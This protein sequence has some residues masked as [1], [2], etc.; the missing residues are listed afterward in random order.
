MIYYILIILLLCILF[1]TGHNFFI[2]KYIIYK[3]MIYSKK[4]KRN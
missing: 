4:E 2:E 3:K 1:I